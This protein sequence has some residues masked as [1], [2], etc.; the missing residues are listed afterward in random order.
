M[1]YDEEWKVIGY[2][3]TVSG[4]K[5]TMPLALRVLSVGPSDE[6][7]ASTLTFIG[8]LKMGD[9]ATKLRYSTSE[10]KWLNLMPVRER[11]RECTEP[12]G[13]EN[14]RC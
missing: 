6:V 1:M 3:L 8:R 12:L 7:I 4:G 11:F 14:D 9:V 2:D 13:Y 10:V 5:A